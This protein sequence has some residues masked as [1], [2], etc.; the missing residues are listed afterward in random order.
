[1]SPMARRPI[2]E[3][4]DLQILHG[5][6]DDTLFAPRVVR[7]SDAHVELRHIQARGYERLAGGQKVSQ[8]SSRPR[9]APRA[10][11]RDVDQDSRVQAGH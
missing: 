7:A 5:R 10:S 2:V 6:T 9:P 1:M 8:L 11:A 3:F 4:Q